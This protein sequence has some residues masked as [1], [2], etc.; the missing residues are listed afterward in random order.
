M[1]GQHDNDKKLSYHKTR[2]II[3]DPALR[4]LPQEILA[5]N[6]KIKGDEYEI[7][8]CEAVVQS[9]LYWQQ[10]LELA[11]GKKQANINDKC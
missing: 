10:Q 7:K 8:G 1:D 5:N 6:P 3:K 11:K 2:F 4:D 9:V